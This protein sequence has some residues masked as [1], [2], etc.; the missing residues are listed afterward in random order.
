MKKNFNLK[1]FNRLIGFTKP[2]KF[3]FIFVSF[4]AI[5]I[6]FFSILNQYF[7]KIAVD[8]YITSKDY[9][10]LL[11]VI[12]LMLAVLCFQ[13]IFQFLFIYFTNLLGQKVVFDLRTKLFNTIIKFK[14][15]YYDKSS[16]G[17]LVTR[18][19]S[20]METIAS[21]FS[22]GL[23]MI[24]ADLILMFSVLVVMIV[25][26]FELSLIIL[27]ILPFVMLATRL[28]QR[29]MKVAFNE[30]RNEVA[31][32]NSFVQERLS[33]IKEIQ[34]FNRQKIETENFKKINERH[35]K[36]WLKTVWYNSIF[37]PIAEIS[38][39]I[40]VGLIVWYAGS[41]IIQLENFVSLGT[42]F[43][44]IQ[45]SQMLFR[46]LRQIADKFNTLQM[47]MVA[48]KRVF[49]ILDSD[50]NI[51]DKGTLKK[52][53]INGDIK[54][55]KVYFSYVKNNN[56]LNNINLRIKKGEKIA[57]V[58]ATGSG[59]STIIKLILR[60]YDLENGEIKI[61]NKNIKNYKLSDLR[62]SISLVNQDIF[63]FADSIFKNITLFNEKISKKEVEEAAK[64][65]GVLE[66]INKLPGGL[67]YNVKERGVM[68]SEGQRQ[69]ISF[70]RAYV[71]KPN[72]LILDE[73]TS[74]IDSKTEE[75]IQ[76]ATNKLIQ[77]KTSIIIAHRLS[78]II[79]ADKIIVMRSGK[80]IEIGSHSELITRKGYYKK[81]Y[82]V[83]FEKKE[84]FTEIF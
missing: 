71:S 6:S 26:S 10:G 54:F 33:G 74:S 5:I 81:L 57:I 73:A 67:N 61:N 62:S 2:Y 56:V 72:I 38:I 59:K 76:F 19:V 53:E 17:R 47:G 7:L 60:L 68:L 31:N 32:L 11:T 42:I 64:N 23:F 44:F 50:Y 15:S 48:A 78:T 55:E 43:L 13:V 27:I 83:Q 84:L 18:T 45:L 37:F 28:F 80:I 40:S 25:L 34:I 65:I 82:E 69:I 8:E 16:V 58:G 41:N 1:L 20:D 70:L 39:S 35:K 12:V 4:S 51:I 46:P 49:E 36:A 22:Q 77:D 63:L 29:A 30:V 9:E 66:F 52:Q 75:L 24:F 14:M 3:N 79:S 21:I